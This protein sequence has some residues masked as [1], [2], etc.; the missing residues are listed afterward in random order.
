MRLLKQNLL[1]KICWKHDKIT[2]EA[3]YDIDREPSY[4]GDTL[5]PEFNESKKVQSFKNSLKSKILNGEIKTNL[6]TYSYT[7]KNK[8]LPKHANEVLKSM[9]KEKLLNNISTNNE[10]I[11]KL[12]EIP[13]ILTKN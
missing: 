8:C 3:N 11:H 1:R 10:R 5:F 4:R 2:G 7:Y 13:L 6:Q 12:K 9:E